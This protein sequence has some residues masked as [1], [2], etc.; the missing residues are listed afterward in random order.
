M[1]ILGVSGKRGVGKNYISDNYIIPKIINKLSNEKQT[2]V[3]YYFSFGTPVKI[4]IYSRDNTNLIN[5][6]NLFINK[7]KETRNLLQQYATENGRDVYRKDMW[8]RAVDMWIQVHTRELSLLNRHLDRKLIP[9][10]IIQDVRF[11]NE[12]DYIRK[13]GGQIVLV[14]APLRNRFR[15]L[16]ESNEN[17]ELFVHE[18]EKGLEGLEF[19]L[20][21]NNDNDDYVQLNKLIDSFIQGFY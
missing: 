3:P 19:D 16:Q 4:E 15:I 10:F 5:Y 14:E 18:S 13:I 9:L 1:Y 8:I 12:Y 17:N 21:I 20:R 6:H 11:Q 7:T 2:I